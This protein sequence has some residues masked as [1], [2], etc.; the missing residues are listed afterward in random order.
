MEMIVDGK[1]V[2]F[3]EEDAKKLTGHKWHITKKGYCAAY[4]NKYIF[5]HRLILPITNGV[6]DHINGNKLDNR[7]ANLRVATHAEN[8]RNRKIQKNNKS[9]YRGVHQKKDGYWYAQIK[10]N[11]EQIFLGAYKSAEQA[12]DA[13]NKKAEE[14]YGD[15]RRGFFRS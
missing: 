14:A 15:F 10:I 5:M 12:A 9:G 7:K 1:Q 6:I 13:Y 4:S 3:D 2:L 11:G 8:M